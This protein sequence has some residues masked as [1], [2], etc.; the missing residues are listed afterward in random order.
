MCSSFCFV[1]LQFLWHHRIMSPPKSGHT[2]RRPSLPLT[3]RDVADLDKIR[4]S[5]AERAAL[6]DLA[7]VTFAAGGRS[8]AE[9]AFLHAVLLAGIRAVHER[10]E[11]ASYQADAAAYQAEDT[12]RRAVARRRRPPWTSED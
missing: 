11:E 9:S 6:E 3:E 12:E 8:E 10:A 1:V 4:N 7:S 5:P 2:I